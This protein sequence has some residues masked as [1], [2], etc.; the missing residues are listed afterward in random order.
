MAKG[1]C[2]L[3]SVCSGLR[4]YSQA[5][6]T[7]HP[8]ANLRANSASRRAVRQE[9][10]PSAGHTAAVKTATSTKTPLRLAKGCV[11]CVSCESRETLWT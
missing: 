6:Q 8:F 9:K 7:T 11:S 1:L 2:S 10:S 3:C 5:A 4:I